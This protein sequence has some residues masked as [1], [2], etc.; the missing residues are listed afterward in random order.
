MAAPFRPICFVVMPFGLRETGAAPPAP[1]RVNFDLLWEQALQPA[2]EKLGYRAVRADQDVGA[3]IINEMLERLYYSDLVIADISIPNAN[4]Y[5]EVGVRHAAWHDG[6][7]L[8]A[9]DWARPVFDLAQVRHLSYPNPHEAVDATTETAII[10][11]L[12][13]QIPQRRHATTPLREAIQGYPNVGR[14]DKRAHELAGYLENFEALRARIANVADLPPGALRTAAAETILQENPAAETSSAS[15]AV[16]IVRLL[17]DV[18]S[19]WDQTVA[20]IEALPEALRNLGY[21]REQLALAQSKQGDHH[22]AIVALRQLVALHGDSPER[23]GLLGGRY[24]RLHAQAVAAGS[25]AGTD[26]AA[27]AA[28]YLER[29]ITHYENGMQLDLNDYFPSCNLPPL[30]RLRG[31]PGDETRARATIA[32]ARLACERALRLRLDNEWT[33]STLLGLAYA[34]GNLVLAETLAERVG[35]EGSDRWKLRS[36]LDTLVAHAAQMSPESRPAFDA[37]TERLRRL[38]PR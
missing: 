23:Q 36:T 29:A 31:K 33:R 35:E 28:F 11:T 5:Y 2:L 34:E 8:I 1:A 17:R 32:V 6:C 12:C 37:L 20:Y 26:A 21:L 13:E 24:K 3:L 19:R 25:D 10:E 9:A 7:V 14:N 30:Y 15:V 4:A 16:E 38:L 18:V 27:E 22:A